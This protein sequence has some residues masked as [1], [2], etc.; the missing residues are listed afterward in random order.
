[1][2][3]TGFFHFRFVFLLN[4]AMQMHSSDLKKNIQNLEKNSVTSLQTLVNLGSEVYMQADV[5]DTRHIFVDVG[6]GFHVE[7]TWSE[8][9]D[10]ISMRE[11]RLAKQIEEHSQQIATINAEIK[12][13]LHS[14]I[15]NDNSIQLQPHGHGH[16]QEGAEQF[17]S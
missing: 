5:P 8:A 11:E 2:N 3:A 10:F 6:M 12:M 7:F 1:M 4:S 14:L 17:F 16:G 13:P 15:A 9:L